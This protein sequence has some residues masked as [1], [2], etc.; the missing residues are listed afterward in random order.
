[1]LGVCLPNPTCAAGKAIE[2]G[3]DD[4]GKA[5]EKATHDTGKAAEKAA[6]DAGAALEKAAHD[7]G[8]TIE[9]GATYIGLGTPIQKLKILN[10][11]YSA[12]PELGK[13]ELGYGLYSYVVL[14]A[15]SDQSSAILNE[16]FKWV[17]RIEDTPGERLQLNI[18]YIPIK[19]DSVDLF[20]NELGTMGSNSP[21]L[22]TKFASSFYDYKM[23][24]TILNHICNPP[25]QAVRDFC[26]G[27]TSRGPYLFT[28]AVPGSSLE[29]VPPPFLFVDLSDV[30]VRAFAEYIAAFRAQVKRD[31]ISDGVR[32]N[33]FRLELLDASLKASKLVEPVGKAIANIIHV[34]GGK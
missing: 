3:A 7:T 11:G 17:A 8:K 6:H 13:E 5:V 31:D 10:T 30:D 24:R 26:A 1:M 32:I 33:S 15:D 29:P 27:D 20:L 12:L 34:T 25:A 28:Y 4:T 9:H 2:K 18:L 23:S 22:G 19:K 16:I 14:S 21:G